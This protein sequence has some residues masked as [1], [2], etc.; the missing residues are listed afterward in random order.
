MRCG[1]RC[2]GGRV[3]S[4]FRLDIGNSVPSNGCSEAEVV[5]VGS[6]MCTVFVYRRRSPFD[7]VWQFCSCV[8]DG[9]V[10]RI[11]EDTIPLAWRDLRDDAKV[12]E[13]F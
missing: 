6:S 2:A 7:A 11:A 13:M 10:G 9:K 12:H 4:V 5:A 3:A 8:Q 1:T